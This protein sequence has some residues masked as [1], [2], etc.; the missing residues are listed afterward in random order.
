ML[1]CVTVQS[2][3]LIAPACIQLAWGIDNYEYEDQLRQVEDLQGVS[4]GAPL[5]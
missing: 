4:R 1:M 5:V 2:E 3:P